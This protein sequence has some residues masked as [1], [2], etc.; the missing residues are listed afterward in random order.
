MTY[1][2]HINELNCDSLNSPIK[3]M[4]IIWQNN[5]VINNWRGHIK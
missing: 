1:G 3:L 2:G 5:I 4:Y